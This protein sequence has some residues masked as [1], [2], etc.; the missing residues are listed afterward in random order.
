MPTVE[1]P[2]ATPLTLHVT[3]LDAM[4]ETAA[5]NC[6]GWAMSTVALDGWTVTVT[7]EGSPVDGP[8][9]RPHPAREMKAPR[10][11]MR[12]EIKFRCGIVVEG[13]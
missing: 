2:P 11:M 12:D 5:E 13:T 8:E 7:A 9:V 10:A 6:C 3:A 4:P 1:L